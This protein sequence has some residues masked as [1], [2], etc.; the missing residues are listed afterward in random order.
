MTCNYNLLYDQMLYRNISPFKLC[1]LKNY[2]SIKLYFFCFVYKFLLLI[3][4]EF[5]TVFSYEFLCVLYKLFLSFFVANRLPYILHCYAFVRIFFVFLYGF[6]PLFA[7]NKIGHTSLHRSVIC[8]I[9]LHDSYT[10]FW[11]GVP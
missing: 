9:F 5:Y 7:T 4:Y 3:S 2:I 6:S 8:T 1:T 10:E 11:H